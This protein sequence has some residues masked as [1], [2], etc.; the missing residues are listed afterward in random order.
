MFLVLDKNREKVQQIAAWLDELELPTAWAVYFVQRFERGEEMRLAKA[1]E[2]QLALSKENHEA[3][4]RGVEGLGQV[5]RQIAD[6]LREEIRRRMGEHTLDDPKIM[7]RIERE[8]GL[9][10][11]PSYKPKARVVHPGLRAAAA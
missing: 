7:R 5:N 6:T 9:C 2:D 3:E 1:I 10:F 8:Y 11:K 4:H